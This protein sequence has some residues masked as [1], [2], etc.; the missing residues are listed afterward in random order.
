MLAAVVGTVAIDGVAAGAIGIHDGPVVCQGYDRGHGDD[1]GF[2]AV[3][4]S[5]MKGVADSGSFCC[6]TNVLLA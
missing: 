5:K 6:Q 1:F 2:V 3:A 4:Q